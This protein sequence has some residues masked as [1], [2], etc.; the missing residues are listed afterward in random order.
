MAQRP[1]YDTAEQPATRLRWDCAWRNARLMHHLPRDLRERRIMDL[2]SIYL[3]AV[4]VRGR[5]DFG[6]HLT[7]SLAQ[8][9]ADKRTVD[10]AIA[11]MKSGNAPLGSGPKWVKVD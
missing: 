10:A 6:D 3:K 4:Y 11:E 5:R 1:Y 7:L 9:L 2:D 8:R